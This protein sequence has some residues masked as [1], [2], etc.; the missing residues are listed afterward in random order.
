MGNQYNQL[1]LAERYQIQALRELEYS[2]R[3]MGRKM[4]RSNKT[5]SREL[6]RCPSGAYDAGIAHR[7]ADQQRQSAAKSHV[8]NATIIRKIKFLLD[9]KMSPEQIAGR[10]KL[11]LPKEWISRQTIYRIIGQEQWSDRLPR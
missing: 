3:Q 11:E 8:R 4:S 1:T 6:K 9:L 2:A 5:I 7:V 10:F